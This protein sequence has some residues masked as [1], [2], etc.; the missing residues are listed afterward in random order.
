[1][2]PSAFTSAPTTSSADTSTPLS[3]AWSALTYPALV[4][5]SD[6]SW[7]P[8]MFRSFDDPG[9]MKAIVQPAHCTPLRHYSY[10]SASL[11]PHATGSLAHRVSSHSG[12]RL[13]L[14]PVAAVVCSLQ[15][16]H[17]RVQFGV[18]IFCLWLLFLRLRFF[19]CALFLVRAI[20]RVLVLAV[21]SAVPAIWLAYLDFAHRM[22]TC[23]VSQL[24][25]FFHQ[26]GITSF[27][28]YSRP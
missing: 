26:L 21:Y 15:Y 1:M 6:F 13:R 18:F 10:G 19:E 22:Q 27:L 20:V 8:Y 14:P 28:S 3:R 4:L 12:P 17:V 5:S 7:S 25:L 9:H 24:L 2:G 16:L 11:Q 23:R